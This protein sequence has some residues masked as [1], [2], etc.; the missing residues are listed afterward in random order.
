MT[1]DESDLQ[2]ALHQLA[3]ALRLAALPAHEQV[4]CLPD[5]VHVADEVALEYEQAFR[6]VPQ[7]VEADVVTAEQVEPLRALDQLFAEMTDAPDKESLWTLSA[8][9]ADERWARSRTLALKAL[10]AIGASPGQPRWDGM[11]PGEGS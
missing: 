3:N 8:M 9:E 5:F 7:L 2:W 6:K 10:T 1:A 4:V 11:T